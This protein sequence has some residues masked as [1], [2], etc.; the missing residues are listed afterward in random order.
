MLVILAGQQVSA[1]PQGDFTIFS[2]RSYI[3]QK[4][5]ILCYFYSRVHCFHAVFD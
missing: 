1:L 4:G 3:L 5:R 2:Q